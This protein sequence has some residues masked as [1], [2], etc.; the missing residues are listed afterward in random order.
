MEFGDFNHESFG[1]PDDQDQ[2]GPGRASTGLKA[3]I[4]RVFASAWQSCRFHW[5]RNA[6]A[7]V[8]LGQHTIVAAAIR[9]AFDQTDRAHA[10]ETWR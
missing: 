3:A 8:S 2:H 10:G 5:M 9:Q 4:A 7:R 6:L 1:D